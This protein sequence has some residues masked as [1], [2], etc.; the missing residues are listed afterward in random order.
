MRWSWLWVCIL[1]LGL[2]AMASN[3][4]ALR[5]SYLETLSNP[6]HN[7]TLARLAQSQISSSLGK[8][9]YATSLGF[10]ARD[11]Y[12]PATKYSK[13]Q[14]AWAYFGKAVTQDPNNTEIRFLRFSFACSTPDFL[15]MKGQLNSDAQFLVNHKAELDAHAL[16]STMY[17]YLRQCGCL[18]NQQRQLLGL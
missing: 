17:A 14:S 12:W 1:G 6:T 16:R 13:A 4:Q 7:S 2:G 9:Y 8:A 3:Q 5:Q 10:E 18:S 11:S 15:D